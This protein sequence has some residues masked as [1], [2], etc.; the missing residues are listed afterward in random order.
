MPVKS[1]GEQGITITAVAVSLLLHLIIFVQLTDVA[2]SGQTQAPNVATRISLNLMQPVQQAPERHQAKTASPVPA[3]RPELK[4][5]PVK[6]KSPV[7]P[8]PVAA[9]R[10]AKQIQRGQ[11]NTALINEQYLNRLLTYIERHKYYPRLA[12]SRGIVG[13]I[14]VSFM[15][16]KKGEVTDL[17]T[18]GASLVLRNAA[19]QTIIS[20]LPLPQLPEEIKS[21]LRVRYIMQFALN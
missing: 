10:E 16:S 4:P 8:E 5:E 21:P 6:N 17:K 19:E 11:G 7:I 3:P 1:K 15:L 12:R 14:K 13:N 9:P 2:I 18:D 20:A